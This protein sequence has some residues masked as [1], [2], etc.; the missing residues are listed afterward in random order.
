MIQIET[1]SSLAKVYP[2]QELDLRDRQ[3][4]GCMLKNEVFS[5]QA[6]FR[7][8]NV[9][10]S[11]VRIEVEAPEEIKPYLTIQAIDYVPCDFPMY[12]TTLK[13]CDHPAPGLFPDIL[14]ELP[15]IQWVYKNSW[16][17]VYIRINGESQEIRPG[18][19]DL[20]IKI[21]NDTV[22]TKTFHLEVLDAALSPQKL[23]VTN[24]F[25]TDCLCNYY[26]MEFDSEEYWRITEN[27]AK[28]AAEY[29]INML[30]TP[31]FTPPLDTA[32]GGERRTIQLVDVRKDNDHYTFGFEKLARWITM[33]KRVGIKYF[34]ISHLFTQWGCKYAPKVM[35]QVNGEYKRI[36][37]WDTDGHGNEYLDFLS[38]LL[39]A[40][41][42]ELKTYGVFDSCYFHVSDEPTGEMMED[43]KRCA[44]FM[45]QYIAPERLFDALSDIAFY[46]NGLVSCPVVAIDHIHPFIEEKP[47]HLWGYYCCGQITSS[48]RFLAYP[49]GRNR[50]LGA[51]LFKYNIE[52]FLQWGF[53]FYNSHLSLE[54]VDPYATSTA[55]GWVPG[56]DPYVVY[57]GKEGKAVPSLRLEVFREALQDLRALEALA[58]KMPKSSVNSRDAIIIALGLEELHFDKFNANNA[59]LIHLRERIN[60]MLTE[61]K[62]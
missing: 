27:F 34:E 47:D 60:R 10:Q 17:A 44:E 46:K 4:D 9:W 40:L 23:I 48:N 30:L 45:R 14:R 50:M 21:T 62:A 12:E 22:Y 28:T 51:L 43:Y 33:C 6:A 24:W 59:E 29:G 13:Q 53:N 35:A 20:T 19:Y 32:Q 18:I 36:F 61:V 41:I 37:G 25:H 55:G 11:S 57:P 8:D 1:L 2:D 58:G 42:A 54:S 56:G 7:I 31:V 38:Q 49:A 3:E 39:P 52:G 26:G 5:F 15:P 16:R